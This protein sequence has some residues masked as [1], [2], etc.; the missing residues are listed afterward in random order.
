MNKEKT[1]KTNNEKVISNQNTV[2]SIHVEFG[3]RKLSTF[4]L[5]LLP[6]LYFFLIT[7]FNILSFIENVQNSKASFTYITYRD[8]QRN[9]QSKQQKTN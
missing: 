9:C 6:L 7:V 5:R 3:C 4:C 1:I 8:V 2:S